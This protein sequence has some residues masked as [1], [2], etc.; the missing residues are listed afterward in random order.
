MLRGGVGFQ[1]GRS[2]GRWRQARGEPS[3]GLCLRATSTAGCQSAE[4]PQQTAAAL[5]S[6][7]GGGTVTFRSCLSW[8]EMKFT[9]QDPVATFRAARSHSGG[10]TLS[11]PATSGALARGWCEGP[12]PPCGLACRGS[13][14]VPGYLASRMSQQPKEAWGGGCAH[15]AVMGGNTEGWKSRQGARPDRR[16]EDR[17]AMAQPPR[18]GATLPSLPVS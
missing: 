17:D 13:Q 7:R 14:C 11:M 12:T 3:Q 16:V 6:P 8:A 9:P 10:S 1:S 4:K 2:G 15:G 5:I 18:Q